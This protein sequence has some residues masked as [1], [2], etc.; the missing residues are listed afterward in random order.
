MKETSNKAY[1]VALYGLL[2]ALATASYTTTSFA[3]GTDEQRAACTPDVF[4]LCG[5]E[6]PNIP[7]IVKCLKEK[8]SQLSDGCRAVFNS[9]QTATR[10]LATPESEWCAFGN[11]PQEGDQLKWQNWCKAGSH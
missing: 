11:S 1:S 5:S 3:L 7:E 9:P 4:K 6:I 10:S 2:F 8:K